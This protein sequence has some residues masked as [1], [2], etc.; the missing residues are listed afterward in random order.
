MGVAAGKAHHHDWLLYCCCWTAEGRERDIASEANR[1]YEETMRFLSQVQ[2]L[3]RLPRDQ[4][5]ILAAACVPVDFAAGATII[6][7]GDAGA[8]F[9]VIKTGEARVEV[10]QED[11][12]TVQ[13]AKLKAG[14]YF[15]ENALLRDE[16]RSATVTASSAMRTLK[17]TRAKFVELGL[18]EKLVFARRKA[19]GGGVRNKNLARPPSRKTEAE[20]QLMAQA[21]Q[22]N[23][24]LHT[25]VNLDDA[26]VKQMIDVAWQEDVRAGQELILQ[27]DLQADFFYI[28]QEGVFRIYVAGDKGGGASPKAKRLPRIV[29]GG[30]ECVN[31]VRKGGS[32]GELALLYL[33]PRAATVKAVTDAKVWVIDRNNFKDILMKVSDKKL[34]EYEEL[35]NRVEIL[36]PLLQEE[37]KA[38]ASALVEMR[39]VQ[40]EVILE[41]GQPGNTFYILCEGEMRVLQN[42][43]ELARLRAGKDKGCHSFGEHALLNNEPR[44]ATRIV[45]SKEAKVLALDR[46]S[47]NLLLGPLQ[48]LMQRKHAPGCRRLSTVS[49]AATMSEGRDL[50]QTEAK[51]LMEDMKVIGLLG[52]GAF[53][54]VEL[55]EHVSN[56]RMYALK[57]LSKGFIVETG[58][59]ENVMNEKCVL[60]MTNSPFIIKLHATYNTPQ[61]LYFLLEPALGGELYQVY[62]TR[63]LAGS[64]PHAKYYIAS[65]VF[66]FEHMHERRII[67]RD[68]KPENLL[69][70]ER[71]H[72]KLADMGLAKFVIG[73][74]YTTCGTP[75]YFAPELIS[76][77]GHTNAVDWWALGVLLFELMDGV[78]PFEGNSPMMI[79]SRVMDGI[80]KVHFPPKCGGSVGALIRDL[81][82]K[83]PS[84]RLPMRPGGTKNIKETSFFKGFDWI[85]MEKLELEPP[86]KP[87]VKNKQYLDNFDANEES[88]P[89]QVEYSD[90][91]SG[92]DEDFAS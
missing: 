29:K 73:K 27:G 38:V 90:D 58:M 33:E 44:K 66:A 82:K 6:K 75:D 1:R 8:E 35:L 48:E 50:H 83:D 68:L 70:T 39:Y 84:E 13:V 91:G 18:K 36:N 56:G 26:R 31:E 88:M 47:F 42:G 30:E 22:S 57:G 7:Q 78:P 21:L 69:F 4:H 54:A 92:W 52:C 11:G 19:V 25:M 72:L 67:Y 17:I 45:S 59:Q 32:F 43:T 87:T 63:G 10:T 61:R 2:L 74:T 85:A 71:G 12:R 86:Y 81:L 40:D 28:V 20:R 77:A 76:S 62:L 24:N 46:D 79:F 23:E 5:P 65:V 3:R 9:F 55:M 34:Q 49:T 37:K 89:K 64:E 51:I 16:P 14:D 80:D 15:G 60:M 41:Q 53:G